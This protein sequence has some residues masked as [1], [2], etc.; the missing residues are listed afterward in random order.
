MNTTTDRINAKMKE[1]AISQADIIRATGA[2]RATVSGWIN[3]ANDP[4]AKYLESLAK[5]LK[6]STTWLLTGRESVNNSRLDNNVSLSPIA[7]VAYAPVISWVQA[8]SWTDMDS[9][10]NIEECEMLPLVP[11]AGKRSFYLSVR[12]LSNAPHFEEGEKICIDPDYD[13]SVIQ[14]GEMVVVKCN[15]EATFKALI[16]EP[17]GYYLKPLNPNWSEQVIPLKDD[18]VL[19]G[20]YVGSFRPAKKFNLA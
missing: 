19:V 10:N 11:G 20:K 8:G 17:N 5:I 4:S 3:G 13:I 14:T 12:G 18:C 6:T 1:H 2:G 7:S 16:V 9:I 15:N